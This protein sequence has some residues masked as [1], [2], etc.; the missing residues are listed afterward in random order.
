MELAFVSER[1]AGVVGKKSL[2]ACLPAGIFLACLLVAAAELIAVQPGGLRSLRIDC[3][4]DPARNFLD[5]TARLKFYQSTG[6]RCLWLAEELDVNSVRGPATPALEFQRDYEQFRILDPG[7]DELELNYSGKFVA[8]QDPFASSGGNGLPGWGDSQDDFRFLTYARD[9]YPHPQLDFIPMEMTFTIP[10][11]WN[12]LGSGTMGPVRTEADTRTYRFVS[13][14]AKG[15]SLVCGRFAPVGQVAG[16]LPARL[17][18]SPDFRY[19]SYFSETDIAQVVS[20]FLER[21]GPLDVPEL[22]ILLRRGSN[23]GGVSYSGLIVLNVDKSWACMPAGKQR[24]KR[25]ESPLSMIDA[26]TDLL[27]HEIAHQWWGGLLSWKNVSDNWITEG[28][29]TY[30]TL[31]YSRERLGEKA[32]RNILRRLRQQVKRN[33]R[34]GAAADG[35]K[36][37]LQYDDPRI[38]QSLVY[39]KP[40]LM[41]AEIA[42]RIGEADLCQ[43][44]RR[45][46]S[47]CRYRNLGTNE[48]LVL[49]SGGDAALHG[50][51]SDWICG[52][53]LPEGA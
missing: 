3:F 41:L 24:E 20:S 12:C 11:G 6:P 29:A 17:Y 21:F 34:K 35:F 18:G 46:L 23:F 45:I 7:A 27:C 19:Q 51:L 37:K 33:A 26:G 44:L 28:L 36:L 15:M 32:Y 25:E 10:S 8:Q 42:D 53:G 5:A 2:R 4:F 9:Y 22:N 48:F 30:A 40:A 16:A 31:I 14:M 47:D 13:G 50:R 38:Y 1:G 43:L 49:L 52:L 39:L